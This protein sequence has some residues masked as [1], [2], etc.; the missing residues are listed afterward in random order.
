MRLLLRIALGFVTVVVGLL[1]VLLAASFVF[2]LATSSEGKPARALWSGP[3]VEADGVL[4]AYQRWGSSGTPIVLVGG[5]VEPTFVW[6]DVARILARSHR[7]YALDLDG[8][9]FSQRRGPW[10]LAE[11]V[12]QVES[13][14]QKLHLHRPVVVGHSL[15]AAVAVEVAQQQVASRAV[16]LDGDALRD[17]GAPT[18]VRDVLLHTPFPT[19]ALRLATRWDWPARKLLA[20]AYGPVHPPLTHDLVAQWTRQLD[21]QG[22]DH[23]LTTMAG[24]GIAGLTRVQL[25]SLH[26]TATVVWGDHDNVDSE[27]TGRQTAG[28]LH[29]PFVVVRGAGHL[30]MLSQPKLVAAAIERS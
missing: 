24:R 4:T 11:W 22:A 14:V 7:V 16:L 20:N 1:A 17:G 6:D 26:I 10:T 27:R 13:F 23:A 3:F 28:D 9:G 19:T 5:F 25:R 18:I 15:G 29:A 21:V 8:F 2:N 12:D 30:S